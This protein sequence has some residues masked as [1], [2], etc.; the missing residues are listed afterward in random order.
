M[1]SSVSSATPEKLLPRVEKEDVKYI[2][3]ELKFKFRSLKIGLKE[4]EKVDL[5]NLK[6]I[7]SYSPLTFGKN[8][9][10]NKIRK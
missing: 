1:Y 9:V 6:I 5:I 4:L 10:S 2:G 3:I 7:S 8:S